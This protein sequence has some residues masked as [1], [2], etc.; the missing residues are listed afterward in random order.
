M[1]DPV[2]WKT[3]ELEIL[4]LLAEGLTD[5]EIGARLHL[6]SETVRWYNKHIYQ[7]LGVNNRTQAVSRAAAHGLLEPSA[8][9]PSEIP[10]HPAKSPI[11]YAANGDVHLSYQIIGDGPVDLLIINGFLSHLEIF[12]EDPHVTGFLDAL[13]SIARVIVF[14]KRGNG[15]SDRIQGA[16]TLENTVDDACCVLAA[17][18]SGRE[19]NGRLCRPRRHSHYATVTRYSRRFRFPF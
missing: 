7:K 8:L 2:I 18:R 6:A 1:S 10:H 4:R 19:P 17:A 14:D 15:L 5:A 13:S 11:Q 3:R 12:W 16:P 9:S